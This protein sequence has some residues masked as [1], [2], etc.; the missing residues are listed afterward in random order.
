MPLSEYEQRILHEMEQ[1][2]YEHDP[3]FAHKVRSKTVYSHAGRHCKWSVV[4]FLAG[5]AV[6]IAFF[7][8][9][10]LLGL[11]GFGIMFVSA[12]T[13]ERNLRRIGKSSVNG[14][15]RSLKT[16]SVAYVL[17]RAH[18]HFKERFNRPNA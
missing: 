13:F 18:Q 3:R 8:T 1:A 17:G 4:T 14:R 9:S 11:L 15:G 6:L 7:S 16:K 5:L 12:I 10:T 2:L